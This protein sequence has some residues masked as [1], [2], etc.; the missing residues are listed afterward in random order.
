MSEEFVSSPNLPQS[1]VC[2]VLISD[3]KRKLTRELSKLGIRCIDPGSLNGISGSERFHADMIVCHVG[4]NRLFCASN[5]DINPRAALR[6]EGFE[7]M[8]TDN[9]VTAQKPAL[10]ICITGRNVLCDTKTVDPT[11]AVFLQNDGMSIL[12]TNQRYTKCSAALAAGNAVITSDPS[13]YE[14]CRKNGIDVLMITPGHIELE[15]YPY[16][17]I[18][19]CCGL[20]SNDTLAFSGDI[21][22]HPD[23]ENIRSFAGNYGVNI[24]SLSDSMLCDIGG[25]IPLKEY[26]L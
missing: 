23:Y 25:I 5:G 6:D 10:N 12:H 22:L 1:K 3:R 9:A 21:T 18:G 8:L 11:L 2:L 24:I 14:L 26:R 16:G 15:G 13:I 20:L 4:G 19:G 7:V 17:F